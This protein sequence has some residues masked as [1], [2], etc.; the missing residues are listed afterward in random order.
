M[1]SPAFDYAQCNI[2]FG[3]GA[4]GAGAK[5]SHEAWARLRPVDAMTENALKSAF[6]QPWMLVAKAMELEN[7]LQNESKPKP[8][9]KI[10][11]PVDQKH[12]RESL[13]NIGERTEPLTLYRSALRTPRPFLRPSIVPPPYIAPPPFL[14]TDDMPD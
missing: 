7:N 4:A 6:S 2:K 14:D 9:A 10:F 12:M 13:L 8:K 5:L 11:K 1:S 3:G